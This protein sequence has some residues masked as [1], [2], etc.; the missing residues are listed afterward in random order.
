MR[1]RP[2]PPEFERYV[3][4]FD[5]IERLGFRTL[6]YYHTSALSALDPAQK[7]RLLV[8]IE[9]CLD[10]TH[11]EEELFRLWFDQSP[12]H[13]VRPATYLFSEMRRRLLEE[14]D[15]GR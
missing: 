13:A 15:A 12:Q 5:D 2:V 4:Y 7:R 6:D 9:S 8:Y 3:S 14:I 1:L 10:G 11:S